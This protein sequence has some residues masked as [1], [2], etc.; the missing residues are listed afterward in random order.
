[1]RSEAELMKFGAT[2][3]LLGAGENGIKRLATAEIR[4]EGMILPGNGVFVSGSI[5]GFG[6]ELKSP[7]N[8][9]G[10]GTW[11]PAVRPRRDLNPSY[12]P[13]KN[14]LSLRI[15]PPIEPPYW[16]CR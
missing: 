1:M 6:S 16:F 15:G 13:K 5:I 9:A 3:P 11:A 7:L 8:C 2:R 12:T 10:V 4:F 14:V